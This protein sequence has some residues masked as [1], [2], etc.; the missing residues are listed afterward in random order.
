MPTARVGAS[1]PEFALADVNGQKHALGDAARRGPVI[2]AFWKTACATTRLIFPYLDRLRQAYPQDSWQL[3][4]IG[5]DPKPDVDAFLGRVGA[6]TFPLLLDYPDYAVARLYDPV[7]TPTLFYVEP[8]ATIGMIAGAFSKHDL[9][10]L[11]ERIAARVDARPIVV[12]PADDGNPP[13]KPG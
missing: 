6:V 4:G 9:N 2:L 7:A 11:S 8:N 12:A 10:A 1:A 13:F 5:Q 3:W